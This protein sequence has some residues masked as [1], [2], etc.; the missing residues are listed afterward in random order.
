MSSA[1]LNAWLRQEND[2]L[3]DL[4]SDLNLIIAVPSLP[5]RKWA[6]KEIKPLFQ[7]HNTS[8]SQSQD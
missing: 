3:Q 4:L 7:T 6:F 1:E 2:D 8:K 5:I